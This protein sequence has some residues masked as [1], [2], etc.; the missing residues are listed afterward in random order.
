M[1]IEIS[2]LQPGFDKIIYVFLDISQYSQENTCVRVSFLTNLHSVRPTTLLKRDSS[3]G[4]FLRIFQNFKNTSG[5]CFFL[6]KRKIY[7]PMLET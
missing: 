7:S 4:V 3:T 1:Q 2:N 6:M 5:G